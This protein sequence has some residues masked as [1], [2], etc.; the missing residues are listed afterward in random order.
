[1]VAFERNSCDSG[2]VLYPEH[3]QAAH[4]GYYLDVIMVK[5]FSNIVHISKKKSQRF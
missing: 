5:N 3:I 4:I 1:M 2:V